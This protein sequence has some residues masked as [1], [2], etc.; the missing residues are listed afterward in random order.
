MRTRSV[1]SW[2]IYPPYAIPHVVN[3]VMFYCALSK[4]PP[5]LSSLE[6]PVLG[7]ERGEGRVRSLQCVFRSHQISRHRTEIEHLRHMHRPNPK[8]KVAVSLVRRSLRTTSIPV[9][10]CNFFSG[11]MFKQI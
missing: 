2:E 6:C 3:F 8:V 9:P 11:L 10:R 7:G 1:F 4:P 5:L